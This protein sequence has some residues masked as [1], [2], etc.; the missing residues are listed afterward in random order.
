MSDDEKPSPNSN[1]RM[2]E[3]DSA[4]P[5]GD[6]KGKEKEVIDEASEESFPASDPPAAVQPVEDQPE[7]EGKKEGS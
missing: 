4:R 3:K 7:D 6:K 1:E 5:G 2:E